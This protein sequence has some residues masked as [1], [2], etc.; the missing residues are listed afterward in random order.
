MPLD[1]F[2][3]TTGVEL[4]TS[5]HFRKTCLFSLPQEPAHHHDCYLCQILNIRQR[6]KQSLQ[7]LMSTHFFAS[8][9]F[10]R[11]VGRCLLPRRRRWVM[12]AWDPFGF[13]GRDLQ[14]K[15]KYSTPETIHPTRKHTWSSEL[16]IKYSVY[17]AGQ[18]WNFCQVIWK[19]V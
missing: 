14:W 19:L 4:L 11:V 13:W 9:I 5:D 2:S 17:K 1:R 12:M 7:F 18:R 10:T 6:K 8:F 16:L 15:I 3:K